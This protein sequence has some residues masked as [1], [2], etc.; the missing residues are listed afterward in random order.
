MSQRITYQDISDQF[1][2]TVSAE[3]LVDPE[4][5]QLAHHPNKDENDE[6]GTVHTTKVLCV[7]AFRALL[8]YAALEEQLQRELKDVLDRIWP[9]PP[10]A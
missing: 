9:E 8:K 1:V 6:D 7:A 10:G 4:L 2:R 3:I 5:W